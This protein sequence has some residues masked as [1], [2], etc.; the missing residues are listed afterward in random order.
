MRCPPSR[1]VAAVSATLCALA[2]LAAGCG[3]EA[4]AGLRSSGPDGGSSPSDAAPTD[5]GA[6]S[7]DGANIT[8]PGFCASQVLGSYVFCADFDDLVDA[9]IPRAYGPVKSAHAILEVDTTASVSAPA[10]LRA[11]LVHAYPS[12][13]GSPDAGAYDPV[14]SQ[15]GIWP[16]WEAMPNGGDFRFSTR[17]EDVPATDQDDPLG[18]TVGGVTFGY[19]GTDINVLPRDASPGLNLQVVVES[20]WT[21]P[22]STQ[23]FPIPVPSN[24]SFRAILPVADRP[25]LGTWIDFFIR[26]RVAPNA[27]GDVAADVTV[28]MAVPSGSPPKVIATL[29][30]ASTRIDY[31]VFSP[32]GLGTHGEPLT[33]HFDNVL[34]GPPP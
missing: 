20:S 7:P 3:S 24:D 23:T 27:G 9:S 5:D 31:L 14:S 18:H 17:I 33:A 34:L 15:S 19:F 25:P 22:A 13:G 30:H 32:V 1:V 8:P 16:E 21:G 26:T 28:S 6:A 4:D 29:H 10:S 11:Q 12:D 2:G